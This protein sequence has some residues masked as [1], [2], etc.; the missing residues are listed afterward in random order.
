MSIVLNGATGITAP[1]IDVTA[2]T[3]V[4]T[5]DAGITLGGSADVL[6]DYE[7]G[8]FT[9][10]IQGSTTAGSFTYNLRVGSYVKVGDLVNFEISIYVTA[11]TT[12]ATGDLKITG[13]PFSKNND[14]GFAS[15]SVGWTQF[16]TFAD[17]IGAY[18][19][20]TGSNITLRN[21]TSGGS[22]ANIGGGDLGTSFYIFVSGSYKAA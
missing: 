11:T 17:Q 22:G 4:A 13:L 3:T 15:A 6:D 7:S 20:T 12:A 9:P 5:F 21:L 8:T 2:Q 18:L 1:D 19:A 14:N 16:I 10:S